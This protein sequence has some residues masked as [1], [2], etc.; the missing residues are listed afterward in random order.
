MAIAFSLIDMIVLVNKQFS[1]HFGK[2]SEGAD[3]ILA[4]KGSPLQSVLCNL[5]HVDAPT[6]NISVKD[7]KAFLNPKHP[8]IASAL[9]ISLGD[10]YQSFRMVGTVLEYFPKHKLELEQGYWFDQNLQAVVGAD[11]AKK[12]DIKIG[13]EILSDHGIV[14]ESDG[15]THDKKIKVVGILKSTGTVQDRLIFTNIS[16][17]WLMHDEVKNDHDSDSVSHSHSLSHSH[18]D[19]G[20]DSDSLSHSHSHSHSDHDHDSVS[21]SD[22]LSHS[23][24]HS[25]HDHDHLEPIVNNTNQLLEFDQEITAIILTMKGKNIQSLNFGRQINENTNL[26]AVNPAIEINRLY[27]LTGSASDIL[28]IIGLVLA[29][30]TFIALFINLLQVMDDRKKE[31]AIIRL[32]GGNKITSVKLLILEVLFI[33]IFGLLIG[34]IM[35]HG[36]LEM[37]SR[38]LGLGEKYQINGSYFC[39]EEIQIAVFAL[40]AALIASMIPLW[41]AYR[42]DVSKTLSE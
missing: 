42:Q 20:H 26:L 8:L 7:A 15:H 5:L 37:G 36:F 9:P 41:K 21:H 16:T 11:V 29:I 39:L 22:S 35:T 28:Y 33:M 31:I 38:Y 23:H 34:F 25:D 24:S 10:S 27:E 32:S 17:Y 12:A 13:S 40:I 6:G 2:S 14:T 3:L 4:A 19:H 1:Q 18:S 30:L